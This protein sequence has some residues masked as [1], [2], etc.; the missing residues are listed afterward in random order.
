MRYE[1][2]I[3]RPPPTSK[4]GTAASGNSGSA[5]KAWHVVRRPAG[6]HRLGE[7]GQ[8]YN[9]LAYPAGGSFIQVASEE[10]HVTML[11]AARS[12]YAQEKPSS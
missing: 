3:A 4:V 11:P 1:H 5:G 12:V 10:M 7:D 8:I 6:L 9:S 2:D